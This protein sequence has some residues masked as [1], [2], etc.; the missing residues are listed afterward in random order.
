[1]FVDES[2]SGNPCGVVELEDWLA[3]S[4]LL[5][6]TRKIGQPV[7]SFI[8]KVDSLFHIRWFSLESEINL[9]GHGS[10]GAGAAILSKYQLSEVSFNSNH[11]NVVIS[12]Q[13][14]CYTIVLPSWDGSA[15]ALP[16]EVSDALI[17]PTGVF[18]TRDLVVVLRSVKSVLDFQ[19]DEARLRNIEDY[20]AL[21]LTAQDGE[22]GYVLR[23][24]APKIGISED[25]ATGSAQ[26][27]LFLAT[28][29]MAR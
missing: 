22:H 20:H 15:C 21:I 13:N 19:P 23:Y 10:L 7:T 12:Q 16:A 11:G 18:A 8:I 2:A 27:S 9:C 1:M 14:G 5:Q 3:D 24:F 6:I 17:N 28:S 25:L 29:C 4:V 26:C